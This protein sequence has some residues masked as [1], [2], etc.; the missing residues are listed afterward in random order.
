MPHCLMT[1][2]VVN[3]FI[4]EGKNNKEQLSLDLDPPNIEGEIKLVDAKTAFNSVVK[5]SKYISSILF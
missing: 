1:A 4:M 5:A 2:Q 3:F